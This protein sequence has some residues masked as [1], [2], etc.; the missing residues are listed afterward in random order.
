MAIE[1]GAPAL[2]VSIIA[3]QFVEILD[4]TLPDAIGWGTLP[5][6]RR[7]SVDHHLIA[8]AAGRRLTLVRCDRAFT[9][10]PV[11]LLWQDRSELAPGPLPVARGFGVSP[12]Y[13][14]HRFCP[15]ALERLDRACGRLV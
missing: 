10:Y 11:G 6:V 1:G 9:E 2:A 7:K 14:S 4:V 12:A 3:S 15:G 5:P 13:P 8:Q